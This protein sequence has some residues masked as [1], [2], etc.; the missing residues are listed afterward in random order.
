MTIN[1]D[2]N[3][4][5]SNDEMVL[6]SG[7]PDSTTTPFSTASVSGLISSIA[8]TNP[9]PISMFC[10]SSLTI[11]P[12]S[13]FEEGDSETF[14]NSP[15][16]FKPRLS[17]FTIKNDDSDDE[18]SESSIVFDQSEME[19]GSFVDI[20]KSLNSDEGRYEAISLSA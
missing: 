8:A 4:S 18:M 1:V 19:C 15:L 7:A 2:G 17:L 12:K 14:S 13:D 20:V 5:V 16:P 11:N 3:A 10:F 9:S 6:E